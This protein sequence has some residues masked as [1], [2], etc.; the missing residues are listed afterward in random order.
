[1]MV[2]VGRGDDGDG[3]SSV[4]RGSERLCR[5]Q[6]HRAGLLSRKT[7]GAF[8]FLFTFL[9]HASGR[10]SLNVSDM[11]RN[12]FPRRD[13]FGDKFITRTMAESAN[14]PHL[15][16]CSSVLLPLL[17]NYRLICLV[18]CVSICIGLHA[19]AESIDCRLSEI[20]SF[21]ITRLSLFTR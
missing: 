6:P 18:F 9:R 14:E 7:R 8:S 3:G 13:R 17:A 12:S 16:P 1:M 11:A 5:G 4:G 15:F 10:F 21:K 2:M 19:T 20:S